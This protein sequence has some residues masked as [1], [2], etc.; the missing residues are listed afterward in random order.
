MADFSVVTLIGGNGFVGRA[1]AAVLRAA[2]HDVRIASRTPVDGVSTPIDDEP[3][4]R[5]AI[6]GSTAVVN[7]VAVLGGKT[8]RAVNVDGAERVARVAHQA[9]VH[10]FVQISA[11]GAAPNAPSAYG[12]S[13]YAGELAV[14]RHYPDATILRPS[15]I[16]GAGDHFFTRFGAMARWLPVMPVFCGDTRFQPVH[17]RNV[18][19]A[20]GKAVAGETAGVYELGGPDIRT[21]RDLMAWVMVLKGKTPRTVDVPAPLARLQAGVLE[22]LPGQMLTRDQLRMLA[23]DNVVAPGRPSFAALGIEPD[24]MADIVPPLMR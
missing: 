17:V 20:V 6:D 10:H 16:F 2:G 13:K 18:G 4:L 9:G 23:V 24:R 21:M 11:I 19:Q 22:H 8:L 5:R 1:T 15:I 3:A 7:L 14:L 12:R